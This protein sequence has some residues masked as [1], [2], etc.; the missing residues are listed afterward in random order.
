MFCANCGNALQEGARFC[1]NCGQPVASDDAAAVAAAATGATLAAATGAG[2]PPPPAPT[3][4]AGLVA[5]PSPA[6]PAAPAPVYQSYAPPPPPP[7]PPTGYPPATPPSRPRRHPALIPAIVAA[8]IIVA[9][10]LGVGLFVGLGGRGTGPEASTTPSTVVASSSTTIATTTTTAPPTTATAA[11]TTTTSQSTTT[12]VDV[13][14]LLAQRSADWMNLLESIPVTGQDATAQIAAF[15]TPKDQA[16][17]R[18][19]QYQADWSTPADPADI[20]ATDFWDAIVATT[21]E[22]GS[23]AVVVSTLKLECRDGL[24]TRGLEALDWKLD[25]GE[26]L[27]TV[28]Y[29][30]LTPREGPM[31]EFGGVV[32]VGD[33]LF[34]S[35][36]LHELKHLGVDSGPATDGMFMTVEFFVRNEGQN[37]VTPAGWQVMA[38]DAGG[39][40]YGLSSAADEYWYSDVEDRA[41]PLLPGESTYL[42]Y[43]FEIPEGLSLQDVQFRVGMPML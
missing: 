24:T 5:P 29:E 7:R 43:T 9:A 35:V 33:L 28:S 2:V 19:A 27:R 26:W 3:G 21:V 17:E 30:P 10:G 23:R 37:D 20:I 34:S 25:G 4:D 11:P 18:A 16:Q 39:K 15:L 8:V 41:I 22:D 32:Q 40:Q 13:A 6:A 12:T 31:V 38:V 42:W 14:A 1:S 36:T